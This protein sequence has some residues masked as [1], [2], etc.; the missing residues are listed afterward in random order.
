MRRFFHERNLYLLLSLAIATVMWLYVAS[1]QN[2]EVERSTRV[3]LRLRGLGSNLIVVRAPS[4]V[5]VRLRG[6]RSAFS[7]LEGVEAWADL[8][9]LYP[10][11]HRV[12]VLVTVPEN[13]RVLGKEPREVVVVVDRKA[14]REMDVEIE[15]IGRLP[16]GIALG[17]PE[18]N[19][20][21]VVIEG[22]QGEVKAVQRV[23]VSLDVNGIR[24]TQT[25]TLSPRVV[26]ARGEFVQGVE[27]VPSAIQVK[28]PV[29]EEFLVKVLPVLPV[30]QGSPAPGYSIHS[31]AVSP[32]TVTT[33]GPGRALENLAFLYTLPVDIE[34]ASSDVVQ[35]VSLQVP[36]GVQAEKTQVRVSVAVRRSVAAKVLKEIPVR[37]TGVPQGFRAKVE[38]G[39]VTVILQA[40]PP[41]LAQ[42][43][44][45]DVT[46]LVSASGLGPGRHTR[47]LEV[48]APL[49]VTVIEVVPRTVTISLEE[50]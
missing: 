18:V 21:R 23:F 6:P 47:P 1:I 45:S 35:E 40:P 9:G 32:T 5:E 24:S 29:K 25:L 30:V 16:P 31:V 22:P 37:L 20:P 39:T 27:V 33:Q 46:V 50:G 28:V 41:A 36:E 2:P 15:F 43:A 17:E 38:P 3:N 13:V 14:R 8:S 11:E 26:G 4:E 19:P 48:H 7:S 42:I 10:G 34:G 12:P 44:A 49:G